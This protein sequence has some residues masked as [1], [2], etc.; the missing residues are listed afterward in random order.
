MR[1]KTILSVLLVVISL[2]LLI[3]FGVSRSDA[4][5]VII[6]AQVAIADMETY[7]AEMTVVYTENGETTRSSGQL[8][9]VSPDRLR[10]MV[11]ADNSTTDE[12]IIVGRM[13]YDREVGS[14]DWEVREWPESFTSQDLAAGYAEELGSL[15]ELVR[16][17][18]EEVDGV[19]C[20]HYKGSVDMKARGEEERAKLDPSEPYYEERLEA[21]EIYDQ[22]QL[23]YELWVGKEDYLLRQLEQN[24]WVVLVKDAGEDTEREEHYNTTAI[25]RFFDFN[26]PIQ[27]EPPVTG[28]GQ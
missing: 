8:E 26:Q 13:Q 18:D 28:S 10:M 15:V 19:D 1:T 2:T 12:I 9:F 27:I 5:D 4:G 21:L 22:W 20:F 16:M 14:D 17:S 25:W 11:V 24:Q 7:R 3:G 6:K 23:T